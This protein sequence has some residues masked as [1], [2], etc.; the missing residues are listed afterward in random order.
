MCRTIHAMLQTIIC[1]IQMFVRIF[2][3]IILMIENVIRMVL[4]T[5]Y[6]FL[7]FL[8]Q[9]VSLL[10]ICCVFLL[11]SKLKCLICGGG[12]GAC[13]GGKGGGICDCLLSAIAFAIIFFIL[14]AT[15]T[16][17]K[18]FLKLGYKP[19]K[20]TGTTHMPPDDGETDATET[21][22]ETGV[23]TPDT[24]TPDAKRFIDYVDKFGNMYNR[25]GDLIDKYGNKLNEIFRL[26]FGTGAPRRGE[27][28]KTTES[29]MYAVKERRNNNWTTILYYLV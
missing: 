2:M 24:T 29:K 17:D 23:T 18:I 5:L 3:T 11:T 28:V 21:N 8:L 13:P 15:G 20:G 1:A 16:L 6:N 9:M 12:G 22:T 7:S 10:P 4:Q 26:P 27:G 25:D 14:R 19:I